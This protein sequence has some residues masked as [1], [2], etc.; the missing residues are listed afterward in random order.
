MN[1]QDFLNSLNNIQ[2]NNKKV[3][4]VEETYEG[5]FSNVVNSILSSC[6]KPLFIDDT[7]LLTYN[8]IL[9]ADEDLGTNFIQQQL[10]PLFDCG[11]ND[12]IVYHITKES[13]S[14]YNIIDECVFKN[15]KSL[16]ELL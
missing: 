10:L 9:D 5:K 7:R 16:D 3:S 6:D 11:D 8:E 14:L 4:M 15:V 12:F 13:W 1:K 2:V